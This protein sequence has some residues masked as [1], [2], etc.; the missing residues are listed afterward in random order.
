MA[1]INMDENG[2]KA[3]EG[4]MPFSTLL[5]YLHK[6]FEKYGE[7]WVSVKGRIRTRDYHTEGE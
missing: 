5:D 1:E 7:C 4:F 6:E 2:E 3:F